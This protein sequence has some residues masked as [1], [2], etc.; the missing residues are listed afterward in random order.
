[1]VVA[2]L[3]GPVKFYSSI[4]GLPYVLVLKPSRINEGKGLGN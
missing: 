4:D 2:A 3:Q 1:V